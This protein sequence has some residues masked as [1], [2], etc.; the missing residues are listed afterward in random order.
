[1]AYVGGK[2]ASLWRGADKV[3]ALTLRD[4]AT[5]QGDRMHDEA[6]KNSPIGGTDFEG[7]G[8]GNL[9]SSWYRKPTNK[10]HGPLG[11][12]YHSVVA[13]DVDYAAYIEH[14]WGLWGPSHSRYLIKP[15][16]A[17]GS[18]RWKDRE[19]GQWV[20]A[21]SV[22]HPGAPGA[23]MLAIAASVVESSW[24]VSAQTDLNQWARDIE[25]LAD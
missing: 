18:L 24:Q 6:V 8:G 11:V 22:M 9:R 14:G 3:T 7:E 10:K 15:K 23:H 13:T 21:K 17:G 5:N 20:Y 25:R 2:I 12:E 16:K 4:I 19:T 1:M